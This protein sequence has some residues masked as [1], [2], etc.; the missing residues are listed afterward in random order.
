MPVPV[1]VPVPVRVRFVIAEA[2]A[3]ELEATIRYLAQTAD[4]YE[5][6]LFHKDEY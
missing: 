1:P 3:G 5:N 4:F 6:T 2:D